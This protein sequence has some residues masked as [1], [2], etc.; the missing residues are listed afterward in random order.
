MSIKLERSVA[1]SALIMSSAYTS[2]SMMYA[3]AVYYALDVNLDTFVCFRDVYMI[4]F[5]FYV[6][7]KPVM[8]LISF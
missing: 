6:T 3:M 5:L 7:N 1:P 2:R 8:D 4:R